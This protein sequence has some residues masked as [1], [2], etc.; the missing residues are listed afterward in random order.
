MTA[1]PAAAG[2]TASHRARVVIARPVAQALAARRPV[3]ALETTLVTH[4]LPHPEGL[5]T[6]LELE[7]EIAAAGATPA[8]IGVLDGAARIGLTHA[9]LER[10]ATGG[11]AAK[12]NLSN[13]AAGLVSRSPGSTTVA[14]TL[15]IAAWAGIETFATGGIGGV[16]RGSSGDVS[17][18]LAAL[19]RFPVAVVCAGAKAVLDLARTV[20]A[21]ETLGVPVYGFRTDRFPAFY[22][23]DS[24]LPVDRSFDS[25]EAL[26]LALRAH[27]GLGATTGAVVANPIPAEFEMPEAL[28]ETALE[29]ALADAAAEA[30]RGRA[31]TPF[32][33]DRLRTL[34]EG[35]SVFSNLALL[36]H[37][38]RVAA[39][40]ARALASGGRRRP[41]PRRP[42]RPRRG[43]ARRS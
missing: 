14:A 13:L 25:I 20:E 30:I 24:G 32:L 35:R 19:A 2:T 28:Y 7:G 43:S 21:L 10:L 4:G 9:E 36:R 23:R 18:D 42:S 41:A 31:V 15:Q 11:E 6:A 3:V 26:A 38:A 16:H 5:A 27:W 12:L 22:R 39:E 37:N 33:L 29:R 34:T 1:R 17:S 40:L 8:T